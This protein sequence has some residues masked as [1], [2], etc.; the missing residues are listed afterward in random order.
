MGL[1]LRLLTAYLA[2]LSLGSCLTVNRIDIEML[3]PGEVS[4]PA[5]LEELVLLNRNIYLPDSIA[6]NNSEKEK[7]EL[8]NIASTEG[9]FSLADI[10]NESPRFG[11]V[12]T[13]M[14]L[15]TVHADSL[16]KRPPLEP[17]FVYHLVDSLEADA[18]VSFEYFNLEDS[19]RTR[20]RSGRYEVVKTLYIE[21]LWRFY[22]GD[23]AGIINEHTFEDT[24][25]WGSSSSNRRAAREALPSRE[26]AWKEAAYFSNLNYARRIAPHWELAERVYYSSMVSTKISEA[27][28]HIEQHEWEKAAELLMPLTDYW[29]NPVAAAAAFNMAFISEMKGNFE[30]GI[31]W[32]EKS[33]EL[34][35]RPGKEEYMELLEERKKERK[36]IDEQIVH[37]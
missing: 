13:T 23:G 34:H 18:V 4:I 7:L 25:R 12:D 30:V 21:A 3:E 27:A 20:A 15:E 24:L 1:K 9:I 31:K 22:E 8:L 28:M 17:G 32:L 36:K 33:M 19:T 6:Q 10:L 29:Y 26:E 37:P 16:H 11:F 2:L 5:G 35:D 14:I